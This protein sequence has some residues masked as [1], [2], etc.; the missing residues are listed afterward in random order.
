MSLYFDHHAGTPLDP[1]VREAMQSAAA[2]PLGNPSSP[3]ASGRRARALLERA[4]EQIAAA[5]GA[6]PAEVVLTSGGTEACNLG[7]MGLGGARILTTSIEH[8]AV[9]EAVEALVVR[10]ARREVLAMDGGRVPDDSFVD[11]ALGRTDLLASQWVNHETGTI[12]PVE[13]WCA[14]AKARAVRSFVDATQ[15][16]GRLR[17]ELDAVGATAIAIASHKIGGP[18]GA[19]ALIVRRDASLASQ[20][21]GGAQERGRRAG[22]PD[23]IRMVG[24]A[25]ACALVDERRRAMPRVAVMRDRIEAFL[26]ARGAVVNGA[27]AS[28]VA[29]V[30]D[31]SIPGWRATALV[32]ALDVEGLEVA[33]G[34]AC[35]SGVEKPSPVVLA[36]Y[37]DASRASSAIRISLGP[38]TSDD[39]VTHAIAILERVLAR[40]AA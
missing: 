36:M 24:M 26:V 29:S 9:A 10:G 27:E 8:P 13:R 21:L 6:S 39:D 30:V 17:I 16:L 4:R 11:A 31:A 19:G 15:A 23:V 7:V 34:A 28:R 2:A 33:A 35:S 14:L 1:R 18:G 38:E 40:P 3:H 25:A 32:A 5:V 12:L 22:T 37:A 20:V